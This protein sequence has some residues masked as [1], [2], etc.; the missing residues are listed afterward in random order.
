M[1]PKPP[2]AG[3]LTALAS[4]CLWLVLAV[5]VVSVAI[6][7]GQAATPP[8]AAGELL[9]LRAVHR[10]AASLE[11]LAMLWLA[12]LAWR[13]RSERPQFARGAA[14]AGALTLALSV[15]GI[16]AGQ[17]PP[18]AAALGN[19]LGGLALAAVFA[20]LIGDLRPC[21]TTAPALV[22]R[23]GGALLVVQCLLG[24]GLSL[25]GPALA[26]QAMLP[27]HAMIGLVLAASAVWLARLGKR[28]VQRAAGLVLALAVPVAGFTALHLEFSPSAAF[29]HAAAAA[30][31]LIAA[32]YAWPRIA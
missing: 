1:L 30:L 18:P 9:A 25:Y 7:L 23:L 10:T 3:R 5:V 17:N 6:R 28:P 4:A 24:A 20:R 32:V 27:A 26:S 2:E 29:A 21:A 16:A 11:V 8:L 15:L 12:G 31:L 19:L 14:L 13:A 22:V